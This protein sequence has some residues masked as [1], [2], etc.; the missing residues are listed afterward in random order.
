MAWLSVPTVVVAVVVVGSV[1]GCAASSQVSSDAVVRESP[2]ATATQSLPNGASPSTPQVVTTADPTGTPAVPKSA[3]PSPTMTAP[4]SSAT[5]YLS[6]PQAG[7]SRVKIVAYSGVADD[8]RGTAINDLGL[9]GAPRGSWGGVAPG[10][11]GNL[12]LT[13][14]RTSAGA[15]MGDVPRLR[16]GDKIYVDQGATRYVYVANAKTMIDFRSAASRSLQAAAV[17]GSPG[18]PATKPAIVLSTCA[19]PEDNAAGN[20]WRDQFDNPTH[21][22]AVYGYLESVAPRR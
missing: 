12:L 14:H 16:A 7:I 15:P 17:P 4:K 18:K 20:Y 8:A 1:A 21:R 3:V 2:P 13:G 22:I 10:Q 5:A 9:V 6:V 19:T 11:V